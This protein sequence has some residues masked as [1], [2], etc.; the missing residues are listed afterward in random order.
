M[1][2]SFSAAWN[3]FSEYRKENPSMTVA[4]AVNLAL[5]HILQQ[6]QEKTTMGLIKEIA[7]TKAKLLDMSTKASGLRSHSVQIFCVLRPFS[8]CQGNRR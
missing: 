4:A 2:E 5:V 1:S 6:S 3:V 7:Q 8:Q